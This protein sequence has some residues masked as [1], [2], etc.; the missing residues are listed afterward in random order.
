VPAA[1]AKAYPEAK[2]DAVSKDDFLGW[3]S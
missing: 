1:F 2:W 3:V